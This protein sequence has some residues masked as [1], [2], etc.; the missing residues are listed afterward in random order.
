MIALTEDTAHALTE[1]GAIRAA[2]QGDRDA[3]EFLYNLHS[4]RVYRVILRIL[5]NDSDAEDLTQQV[6][7]RLFRKIG[8][9]RGESRFSTWLH[10]MAVNAALMHLRRAR[11]DEA[12]TQ[13]ID[14]EERSEFAI[15]DR[16]AQSVSD[17]I[18]LA[19]ALRKL[20]AGCRRMFMLH[21]VLGYEHQEIAKLEG[22]SVGCSK[23]QVHKARKRLRAYLRS[24]GPM[25]PSDAAAA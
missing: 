19:R 22:C 6:F 11:P 16:S 3:F 9:F 10:R 25:R 21:A 2:Q 13:S 5:R 23:S 18:S 17:R 24:F 4:R 7:L 14:A 15:P 8:T 20:P 12:R 1:S